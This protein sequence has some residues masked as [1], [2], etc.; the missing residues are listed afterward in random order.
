MPNQSAGNDAAITEVLA[1]GLLEKPGETGTFLFLKL[2]NGE[3][4]LPHVFATTR[5]DPIGQ[6]AE[7]YLK[8]T[9]VRVHTGK[10][11]LEMFHKVEHNDKEQEMPCIAFRMEPREEGDINPVPHSSKGTFE[12][13]TLEQAKRKKLSKYTAWIKDV[14]L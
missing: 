4:D 6:I 3:Y 9:G 2:P 10:H 13:L 12:W 5:A 8:Q 7:G 11:I 14:K 1:C